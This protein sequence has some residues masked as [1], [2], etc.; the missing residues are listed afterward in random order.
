[1]AILSSESTDGDSSPDPT[2][3]SSD[4]GSVLTTLSTAGAV[5]GGWL[6]CKGGRPFASLKSGSA[7]MSAYDS[8]CFIPDTRSIDSCLTSCLTC[9]SVFGPVGIVGE[10]GGP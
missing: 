4:G 2:G 9:I 7:N 1:M 5:G 6:A 10:D 3:A 8:S